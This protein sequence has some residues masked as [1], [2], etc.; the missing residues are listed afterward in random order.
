MEPM[1]PMAPMKPMEPMKPMAPMKKMEPWWPAD[2]GDP[3]SS[4]SAN[5]TSYAYFAGKHRLAVKDGG[6]VRVYDSGP[7]HISGFGQQQSSSHGNSMTFTSDH[8]TVGI[9]SMKE[10]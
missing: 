10:V 7:N 1:K 6:T 3:T 5:D 8:G 2:L 9:E 4:G